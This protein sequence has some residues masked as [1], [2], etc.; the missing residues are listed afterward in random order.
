MRQLA[1]HPNTACLKSVKPHLIELWP[2]ASLP[3]WSYGDFLA[4]EKN[5]SSTAEWYLRK[6]IEIEPKSEITNYYMGKHLLYWD[7]EKEAK[8]FLT[9]AA[10]LGHAKARKLLQQFERHGK[11]LIGST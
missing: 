9:N 11:L 3:Y 7:R 5:D 4:C 2:N 8:S 1:Q 6:A 10:R